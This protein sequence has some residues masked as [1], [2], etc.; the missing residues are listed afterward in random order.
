[1][2]LKL[3]DDLLQTDIYLN[4]LDDFESQAKQNG[5]NDDDQSFPAW[6]NREIWDHDDE[7]LEAKGWDMSV[8]DLNPMLM[9]AHNYDAKPLGVGQWAVRKLKEEPPGLLWRPSFTKV[10]DEGIEVYKLYKARVLRAFSAGFKPKEIDRESDKAGRWIYKKMLLLEGSA[11]PIPANFLSLTLALQNDFI[12]SK[13]LK[14]SF[15]DVLS[16]TDSRLFQTDISDKEIEYI[17]KSLGKLKIKHKSISQIWLEEIDHQK[18]YPN[19]HACRLASPE[20]AD[21]CFRNHVN[22]PD[23]KKPF[24]QIICY[25]DGKSKVQALRYKKDVW[26]ASEARAHCQKHDPISFEPASGRQYDGIFEKAVLEI[27]RMQE[28]TNMMLSIDRRIEQM[29]TRL[30]NKADIDETDLYDIE[31]G[32]DDDIDL[33]GIEVEVDALG[34]D[35]NISESELAE[36]LV[37]TGDDAVINLDEFDI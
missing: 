35:G 23:S 5:F 37:G 19:E 21:R 33:E 34:D 18:P 30:S 29:E 32:D 1:M 20:G 25:Y 7:L 17:E 36:I 26:T 12:K 24:D 10:T 2:A 9:W 4:T 14:T 31:I 6:L 3:S 8:W 27:D 28:L 16:R 13:M 15:E 22:D 11:V